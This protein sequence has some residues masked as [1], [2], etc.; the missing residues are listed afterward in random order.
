MHAAKRD[1]HY[2]RRFEPQVDTLF[3][4]Q[5]SS[6]ID[7]QVPFSSGPRAVFDKIEE[8]VRRS[9]GRVDEP[10]TDNHIQAARK[11]LDVGPEGLDALQPAGGC[12]N[13]DHPRLLESRNLA[14]RSPPLGS[15]STRTTRRSVGQVAATRQER[16][17]TPG[18]P[19]SEQMATIVMTIPQPL[20][21]AVADD[22]G[23][24]TRLAW[25]AAAAM[26][27][28][29]ASESDTSTDTS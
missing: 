6:D 17:V 7:D 9:V 23:R 15:P 4:R 18:A 12:G 10:G 27:T 5:Q 11:L 13:D 20:P 25:P 19:F 22:V 16:V 3:P 8:I 26:D 21:V 29:G 2:R 24:R 1:G 14:A 28:S